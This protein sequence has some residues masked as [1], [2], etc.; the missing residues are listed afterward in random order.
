MSRVM[1]RMSRMSPHQN[2]YFTF[3]VLL[4]LVLQSMR[5]YYNTFKIFLKA[6][7][8]KPAAARAV[9]AP[10]ASGHHLDAA[11]AVRGAQRQPTPTA[12]DASAKIRVTGANAHT[13]A[14]AA[15]PRAKLLL[16]RCGTHACPS[17]LH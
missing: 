10:A 5:V 6:Q 11:A 9:L 14:A 17:V 4:N 7:L 15:A 13:Q 3:K 8:V 16:R 12:V 1:S 2:Y